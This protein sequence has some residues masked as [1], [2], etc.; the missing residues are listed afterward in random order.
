MPPTKSPKTDADLR[1]AD[2]LRGISPWL[3]AAIDDAS[4]HENVEEIRHKV[5]ALLEGLS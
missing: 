1:L 5:S 3:A 2:D 4:T